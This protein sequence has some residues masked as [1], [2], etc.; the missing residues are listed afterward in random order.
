MTLSHYILILLI[1]W[2]RGHDYC[3]VNINKL[4]LY[5]IDTENMFSVI[6]RKLFACLLEFTLVY[7]VHLILDSLLDTVF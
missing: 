3:N 4:L 7:L 1:N 6:G 5:S 2:W